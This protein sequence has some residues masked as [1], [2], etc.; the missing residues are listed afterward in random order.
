MSNTMPIDQVLLDRIAL[1]VMADPPLLVSLAADPAEVLRT[2]FGA[3]LPQG[4][5]VKL[6]TDRIQ[7]GRPG[8]MFAIDLP[9]AV[10][11]AGLDGELPDELLEM[12][13]GGIP[14]A[15]SSTKGGR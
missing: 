15:G 11:P 10:H 6:S 5:E 8:E 3:D 7:F 14:S 13:G 2:R 12:A 4:I 9:E 1:A